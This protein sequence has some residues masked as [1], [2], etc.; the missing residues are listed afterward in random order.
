MKLRELFFES[1]DARVGL[2]VLLMRGRWQ[3]DS[4]GSRF[5]KI[6]INE[7]LTTNAVIKTLNLIKFD[8]KLKKKCSDQ[9]VFKVVHVSARGFD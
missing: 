7:R 9:L 2:V 8:A 3:S 4:L 5:D 1:C 6:H